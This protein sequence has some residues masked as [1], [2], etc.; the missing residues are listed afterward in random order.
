MNMSRARRLAFLGFVCTLATFAA[1]VNAGSAGSTAQQVAPQAPTSKIVGTE[2]TRVI[3]NGFR[4]VGRRV[5]GRGTE[6]ATFRNS[7]TGLTTVRR[8]HFR[9][10]IRTWQQAQLQQTGTVCSILFLE[11]GDLDLTLA[12][13]HATLHAA[14][15]T[16]PVRLTLQADDQGGILG[17]LFC[18]LSRAGGTLATAKKAKVAAKQLT[19][20]LR[21][22]SIMRVVATIYAPNQ[23]TNAG[24]RASVDSPQGRFQAADECAVLHLVLG[25]LHLDLLGLV[26]DLNKVVL[27]LTAVPGTL[28]GNIFCQLVTP[29]PPPAPAPA[30]SA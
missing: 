18:Q 17:R 26:V 5:V 29:P 30:P 1:L 21:A 15:P 25:P 6:V 28:L 8:K 19:R 27:D 12:G 20:H 4:N 22:A 3:I 24:G 2:T 16:E 13:L 7:A 10:T 11:L 9:L 14:D 23:G